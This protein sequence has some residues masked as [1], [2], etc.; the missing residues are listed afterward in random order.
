MQN[1]V[2][3][4]I[5]QIDFAKYKQTLEEYNDSQGLLKARF[6]EEH[7]ED[8]EQYAAAI[9]PRVQRVI[10]L[11]KVMARAAEYA[12]N[13]RSWLQLISIIRYS[14][15]VFSYDLTNPLELTNGEGWHYILL[16]A[17]CSL[18]LMEHLQKGGSLR[19][20][21]GRDIDKVK[22]QQ[23]SF[24][25][26]AQSKT[27]AFTFEAG[28]EGTHM[29]AQTLGEEVAK[30]Q[31]VSNQSNGKGGKWFEE[32]EDFEIIL[33]SSLIGFTVQCLMAVSKWESL[34]DIS[35]R[36]NSATQNEFAT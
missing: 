24:D 14:W 1:C 31:I 23:P 25:K 26:D 28:A 36:L 27:V 34:V 19:R 32:V 33:H 22:N 21:A 17:E 18:F 7:K 5:L 8:N 10:N 13:S 9:E 15:N 3:N 12:K 2:F 30:T 4:D 20:I 35:N 6:A 29:E 11:L 16:I